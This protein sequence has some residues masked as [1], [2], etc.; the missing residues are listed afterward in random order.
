MVKKQR[1][2]KVLVHLGF[3]SRKEIKKLAKEGG[4]LVNN[5]VITDSSEHVNPEID[6]IIVGGKQVQ[7]RE[8]IYLMLNKPTGVISATEDQRE[9]TVIDLINPDFQAF[10]PF[11]VGRLDKDTEGLLILTNDGKLAHQLL[12]P[13]KHI[14]KTY[15]AK[16]K[17]EV[18]EVDAKQ[19]KTGVILDDG[20]QTLPSELVITETGAISQV[21]IT[22]YEGKYHQVKRM[23]LAV[24]KE[25]IYLKRIKM[26]LLALDEGLALGEY[27]ELTADELTLIKH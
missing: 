19:F 23:F 7:Y 20:Y 18:T 2:D 17:G 4:I 26:G 25:V 16:V 12:S 9:D 8:F 1:L 15:Y 22:I 13:K 24:G 5:K 21:E 6:E 27:R 11:P 14:P 3:G 10:Q